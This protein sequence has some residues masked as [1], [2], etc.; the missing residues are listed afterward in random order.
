MATVSRPSHGRPD[1]AAVAGRP[2]GRYEPGDINDRVLALF[3]IYRRHR[4]WS[5]REFADAAGLTASQISHYRSRTHHPQ[6]DVVARVAER[7][8]V[9]LEWLVFGAGPIWRDDLEHDGI[10]R[11][12]CAML[13]AR[14][15]RILA[16]RVQAV[17]IGSAD[18]EEISRIVDEAFE[19]GPAGRGREGR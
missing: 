12:E 16:R 1:P 2:R 17:A 19:R 15:L 7:L 11:R 3:E 5:Q 6:V 9:S 14:V 4:G 13:I 8:G 18:D 10:G